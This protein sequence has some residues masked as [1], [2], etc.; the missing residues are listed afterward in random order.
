MDIARFPTNTYKL[1]EAI[2][3]SIDR[4]VSITVS[5]NH[6]QI[7]FLKTISTNQIIAVILIF[8]WNTLKG[9]IFFQSV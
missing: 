3:T 5:K 6:K 2:K 9:E 4:L 8:T 1:I 7:H